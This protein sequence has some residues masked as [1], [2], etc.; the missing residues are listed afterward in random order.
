MLAFLKAHRVFFVALAVALA[1]I[2]VYGR[3]AGFG[4]VNFDDHEYVTGNPH[5][6]TGLTWDNIVWA[7]TKSHSCNWHPLTWI[8][9]M[10]DCEIAGLEGGWHHVVNVLFHI[11]NTIILFFLFNRLTGAL[12]RS[13]FVAAL[14]ALHPLHVESV[15]WVSE[16]KDVLS[17]FFWLLTMAAYARYARQRS[18]GRYVLVLVVFALGLMSKPMLVTL[19]VVLLLFDYWPLRRL[20]FEPAQTER[21]NETSEYPGESTRSSKFR[22]SV[23]LLLEKVPLF[24]MAGIS[25]VITIIVQRYTEAPL[26]A[27][28]FHLR[29]ANAFLSYVRYLARMI[30][31]VRLAAFY[32]H[33]VDRVPYLMAG[34]A[35]VFLVVVSAIVLR[36]ARRQRYLPF[37]WLWYLIT[38]LPV[39]GIIQVGGQSMADRYTYVPLIGIFV[40]IAWG[41]PDVLTRWPQCRKLLL[42]AAIILLAVLSV[43]SFIQVGY[44]SDTVVLFEHATEVTVDNG[45][46]HQSV[47]AAL[48]ERGE[49]DRAWHHYQQALRIQPDTR[50]VL[51]GAGW[52]LATAADPKFRDPTRAFQYAWRACEA[53]D[54]KDPADLD[55]LAAAYAAQ[56][57]FQDAVETARKALELAPDAWKPDYRQR[58]ELYKSGKPYI[59]SG[60][61]EREK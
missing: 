10:I 22:G 1:T 53:S 30:W 60:E 36:R 9:H 25:S 57:R 42:P 35:L 27:L 5:V 38:L 16:R 29:L 32:P 19:P 61:Q 33:P 52:F 15:A 48:H 7:F 46:M 49:L 50:E 8:S 40:I 55:T 37:G 59:H 43:L 21:I 56:G 13:A 26:E 58:L 12:W 47:A 11:A 44:W 14:F 34:A 2:A 24:G 3:S 20:S 28:A 39:I 54:F 4:F 18:V 41:V 17:T 45:R 23:R 51:N 6:N 31:P